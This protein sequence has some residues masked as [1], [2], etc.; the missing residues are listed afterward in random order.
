M[1]RPGPQFPIACVLV[2][3]PVL[4]IDSASSKPQVR[5]TESAAGQCDK[6]RE[7]SAPQSVKGD[8]RGTASSV[9]LQNPAEIAP[10]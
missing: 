8:R 5:P 10:N 6:H 7:S 3:P 2:T 4:L 1:Q 9:R